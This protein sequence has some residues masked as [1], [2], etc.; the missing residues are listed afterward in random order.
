MVRHA[1]QN[2]FVFQVLRYLVVEDLLLR[3]NTASVHSLECSLP[4][5]HLFPTCS[6]AQG[7]HPCCVSVKIVEDHLIF[8]SAAGCV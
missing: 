4:A 2:D 5:M 7:F 1:G 8:F 3:E 6:I